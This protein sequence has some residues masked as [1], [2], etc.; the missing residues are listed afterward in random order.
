MLSQPGRRPPD[1]RD[2]RRGWHCSRC[3]GG[4]RWW[5]CQPQL[6]ATGGTACLAPQWVLACVGGAGWKLS[7][8]NRSSSKMKQSCNVQICQPCVLANGKLHEKQGHPA[9]SQHHQVLQHD[10]IKISLQMF[11]LGRRK[12]IHRTAKL[13]VWEGSHSPPCIDRSQLCTCPLWTHHHHHHPTLYG[14]IMFHNQIWFQ[15]QI[16]PGQNFIRQGRTLLVSNWEN[17]TVS[18]KSVWNLTM[19]YRISISKSG[20]WGIPVWGMLPLQ[21]CRRCTETSIYCQ[22]PQH[23]WHYLIENMNAKCKSKTDM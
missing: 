21:I 1:R 9:G 20:D 22:D 8:R 19:S 2:S 18:L 6:P 11:V 13:T 10:A 23:T 15:H 12:N 17:L 16:W 4:R 14:C 3:R 7:S 5:R